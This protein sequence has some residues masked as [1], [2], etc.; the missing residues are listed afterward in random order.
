MAISREH[1][2][3]PSRSREGE[4]FEVHFMH[5][6]TRPGGSFIGVRD[7]MTRCGQRG[8]R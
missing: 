3:A 5:L 4:G 8:W 7:D 1:G 2:L 6:K